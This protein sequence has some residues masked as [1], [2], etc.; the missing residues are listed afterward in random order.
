V[1]EIDKRTAF[2]KLLLKLIPADDLTGLPDESTQDLQWLSLKPHA[3]PVLVQL[4][5]RFIE[6]E[7]TKDELPLRTGGG[8]TAH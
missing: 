2:P 6:Q 5:R 7:G 8:L 4:A 1:I 3:N